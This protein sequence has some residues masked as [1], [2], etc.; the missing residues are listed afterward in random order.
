MCNSSQT[1]IQTISTKTV[2]TTTSG[3]DDQVSQSLYFRLIYG[4][5]MTSWIAANPNGQGNCALV[6]V[7]ITTRLETDIP[8]F[9]GGVS[10]YFALLKG[11][12]RVNWLTNII[13]TLTVL[14]GFATAILVYNYGI[15]GSGIRA[16]LFSWVGSLLCI[17]MGKKIFKDF[18][19]LRVGGEVVIIPFALG[20]IYY[21]SFVTVLQNLSISNWIELLM[22]C[23]LLFLGMIIIQ[24][25]AN[26]IIY[27]EAGSFKAVF[28]R[29][30][31]S[32]QYL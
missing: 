16:I 22:I 12:G 31:I 14:S 28:E 32:K 6:A 10:V 23:L 19:F 13:S 20:I 11:T 24:G 5:E 8:E 3:G 29:L 18:K 4:M 1:E 26:F 2:D 17:H 30:K 25:A 15:I 27:K 7:N 21:F 9:N